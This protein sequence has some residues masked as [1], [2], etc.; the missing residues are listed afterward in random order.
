MGI[1]L[2]STRIKASLVAADGTQLA[3]GWYDWENRLTDGIWTYDT[4]DIWRG[5]AGAYASLVDDVRARHLVKLASVAA[6]GFSAMMHGYL[7]LDAAGVLLV[8]F[9]TWRNNITHRATAV[10]TPLLD[11]AVPQRC[12]IALPRTV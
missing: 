7:G 11:F 10:L 1:E 3:S 6:M 8:P 5:V 12:L 2:G 9:R 4:A